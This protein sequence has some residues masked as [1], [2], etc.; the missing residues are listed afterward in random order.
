MSENLWT[1]TW[2]TKPG[3]YWFFG[4]MYGDVSK[5]DYHMV[6]VRRISNGVLYVTEGVVMYK[7]ERAKGLW[8]PCIPPPPKGSLF[9]KEK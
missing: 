4:D 9:S 8:C 7:A 3:R 6:M 5:Y 2:P 1:L